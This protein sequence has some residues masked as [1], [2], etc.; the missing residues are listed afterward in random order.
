MI[1]PKNEIR[2]FKLGKLTNKI[3]FALSEDDKIDKTYISFVIKA[4]S[5]F[6]PKEYQGLA[7]FLEHMIFLGSSKYP[8]ENYFDKK[9][10]QYGG[11]SNAYTDTFETVYY[12]CVQSNNIEEI[13]DI[14]TMLMIDP[15]FDL[16]S[17]NREINAIN[18]EHMKNINNDGWRIYQIIKNISDKNSQINK[19]STGNL[20]TL[21]KDNVRNEM[22]KFYKKYYVSENMTLSIISPLCINKL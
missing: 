21:K 17:V 14:F 9:L 4:G 2:K 16:N 1:L 3:K 10:K 11:W 15:L 13:L 19:F 18:S 12:F 22:I 8:K 7:H 5:F 6:D 20:Q